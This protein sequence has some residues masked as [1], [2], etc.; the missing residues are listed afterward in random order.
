MDFLKHLLDVLDAAP[1]EKLLGYLYMIG[2]VSFLMY[3]A[4]KY[5]KEF[6]QGIKGGNNKL[7]MPEIIMAMSLIV[8]INVVIAD[9]FLGL[10]PSDGVFWSLN[11][12]IMYALTHRI[13]SPKKGGQALEEEETTAVD[14]I[15]ESIDNIKETLKGNKKDK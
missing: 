2:L 6:W 12:V 5:R 8:Y 14:T 1:L 11:G 4:V 15:N 3:L 13:F 7:E 10:I 9:T